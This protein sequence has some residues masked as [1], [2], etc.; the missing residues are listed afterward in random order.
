MYGNIIA[1]LMTCTEIISSL[2]I[3][4]QCY[5]HLIP[6]VSGLYSTDNIAVVIREGRLWAVHNQSYHVAILFQSG[7]RQSPESNCSVMSLEVIRGVDGGSYIISHSGI[8]VSETIQ[9][10][11]VSPASSH[12]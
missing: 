4:V 5:S 1:S 3:E 10:S 11:E 2:P 8:S 7:T 12:K 6:D 9:V